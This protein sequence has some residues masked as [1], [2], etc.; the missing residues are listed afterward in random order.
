MYGCVMRLGKRVSISG[1]LEEL[2]GCQ[3]GASQLPEES[4]AALC[5]LLRRFET[6]R[7]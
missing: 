2:C 7:L 6:Q 3:G 1:A 5:S 4:T